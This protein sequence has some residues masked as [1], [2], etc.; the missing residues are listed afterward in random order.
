MLLSPTSAVAQQFWKLYQFSGTEQLDYEIRHTTND[1]EQRGE[2]RMGLATN[3]GRMTLTVSASLGETSCQATLPLSSPQ[4]LPATI[5]G[6]CM[7]IA[8]V[9]AIMF[10][11]TW[12]MFMSQTWELVSRLSYRDGDLQLWFEINEECSYVGQEGRL[13]R[14]STAEGLEIETC[15]ALDVSLPLAVSWVDETKNEKTR[16]W[17]TAYR[18]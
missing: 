17:L 8:P 13:A 7:M 15:V 16:I 5:L 12:M 11:P 18:P 9:A 1:R 10:A 14:F 3:D 6:Q 4:A 2:Y